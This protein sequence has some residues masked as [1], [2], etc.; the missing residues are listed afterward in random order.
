[1]NLDLAQMMSEDAKKVDVKISD[2]NL[3]TIS[4]L[5]SQQLEWEA[6]IS[7]L[8]VDL[9]HATDALRQIQEYLLPEAM[10]SVGMSEFK[11]ANGSKITIKD[12]IFASIRKDYTE[13]AVSWLDSNGLGDIVKDKININFGRGESEE[14]RK[15][16]EFCKANG[17][18]AGETLS[19]H[20]QTLKAT[21]KEQMSRGVQFPEEFFSIAPV[22]KAIIKA[23]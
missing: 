12:D 5:A 19:V 13:S 17:Y 6:N 21:I 3:Q 2:A 16:I 11:L 4:T 20:P 8:T 18:D 10:V 7:Q 22:R 1:M 15:V 9:G 23:K 14:A